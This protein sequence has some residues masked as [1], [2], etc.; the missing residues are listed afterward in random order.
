MKKKSSRAKKTKTSRPKNNEIVFSL[1]KT[2]GSL[3][4]VKGED[5]DL[6]LET[7]REL[8]KLEYINE[9]QATY[10]LT[11]FDLKAGLLKKSYE[12]NGPDEED[13]KFINALNHA[14]QSTI[15]D[16]VGNTSILYDI[17]TKQPIAYN[18]LNSDRSLGG[19]LDQTTVQLELL[20]EILIIICGM[21]ASVPENAAKRAKDAAKVMLN[22]STVRTILKEILETI[23][24]REGNWLKKLWNLLKFLF[25][26]IK[27]DLADFFKKM[28][29][30]LGKADIAKLVLDILLWFLPFGWAKKAATLSAGFIM[31]GIKIAEKYSKYQSGQ[32]L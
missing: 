23:L 2:A 7:L 15:Y 16:V 32:P 8:Q 26:A 12:M 9:A 28:F 31:L 24:K 22:N 11:G 27:G 5:L 4:H 20:G 19:F 10:L 3:E 18:T 25:N 1:R 29:E 21:I 6:V 13:P 14:M 30:G 17:H